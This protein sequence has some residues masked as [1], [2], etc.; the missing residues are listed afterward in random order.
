MTCIGCLNGRKPSFLLPAQPTSTAADSENARGLR[1]R[2]PTVV[3]LAQSPRRLAQPVFRKGWE[4]TK[5]LRS[6]SSIEDNLAGPLPFWVVSLGATSWTS[7]EPGMNR[8][9]SDFSRA[10]RDC[11]L[12]FD[13]RR[14]CSI[15]TSD[16]SPDFPRKLDSFSNMTAEELSIALRSQ[17]ISQVSAHISD[18]LAARKS[19][20]RTGTTH[21]AVEDC[22]RG[23]LRM[24]F[25]TS[26][27][28]AA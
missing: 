28:I 2:V 23:S 12:L 25:H 10:V 5:N 17:H 14:A 4:Q 6:T 13:R 16:H 1:A 19:M 11:C 7:K 21:F 18:C 22:S 8:C 9:R 3:R 27:F 26:R 24:G 15:Q 20:G